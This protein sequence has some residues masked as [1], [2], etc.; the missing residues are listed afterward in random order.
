MGDVGE[1]I[2]DKVIVASKDIVAD[3]P[4]TPK[5][6]D[7]FVTLQA[8][9][10]GL[11]MYALREDHYC[12]G[13]CCASRR[14]GCLCCCHPQ[15]IE[16]LPWVLPC[17]ERV[18]VA[19]LMAKRDYPE[20]QHDLGRLRVAHA[21]HDLTVF[22]DDE[23]RRIFASLRGTDFRTCRDLSNDMLIIG[24]CWLCRTRWVREEYCHTRRDFPNYR[25]Y[26]CGHS[27]GGTVMTEL[28]HLLE[29]LPEFAF[30]RVDVFNTGGSPLA[31]GYSTLKVTQ[32]NAHRVQG[33]IVSK[34]FKAP[35][36]VHEH[37]ARE[38]LCAHSLQHFLPEPT[39][40]GDMLH[41][42]EVWVGDC[43]TGMGRRVHAG[44][45]V[46][47]QGVHE[48]A[49]LLARNAYSA[50]ELVATGVLDGANLLARSAN[51]A[52]DLVS[53]GAHSGA[54]LVAE[55]LDTL[56]APEAAGEESS[57][58]KMTAD[59]DESPP[60]PEAKATRTPVAAAH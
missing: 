22:V 23:Q 37:P 60:T 4:I 16:N 54:D 15:V 58:A 56:L 59:S 48:G 35:G 10:A 14:G 3:E 11:P 57:E 9:L 20:F 32:Y 43:C 50:G 53:R 55:H 13:C 42:A 40:L 28:A 21:S 8:I 45:D 30:E 46:M 18:E 2:T 38:E 39:Q 44:A 7:Q 17:H 41:T 34:Y 19:L 47:S 1:Q 33:D 25:S 52:G 26:G 31:L 51:S 29:D 27:L 12:G 24:G 5:P 6:R 49:H 36:K